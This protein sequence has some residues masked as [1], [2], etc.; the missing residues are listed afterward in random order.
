M[1]ITKVNTTDGNV[2]MQKYFNGFMSS[3]GSSSSKITTD[4][5]YW[6]IGLQTSSSD[7]SYHHLGLLQVNM[8]LVD[9]SA[10]VFST[11]FF[12]TMAIDVPIETAGNIEFIDLLGTS[13]TVIQLLAGYS[14]IGT[15]SSNPDS[16]YLMSI[17][18]LYDGSAS[19]NW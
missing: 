10:L 11:S 14:S 7:S 16:M 18:F 12:K 5:M 13:S 2:L 9:N 3:D 6:Y 19:I 8:N 1:Y 17:D 15:P 4:D